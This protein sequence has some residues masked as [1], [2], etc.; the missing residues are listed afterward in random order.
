MGCY[1]IDVDSYGKNYKIN[2]DEDLHDLHTAI[3]VAADLLEYKVRIVINED[4]SLK[5]HMKVHKSR[6]EVYFVNYYSHN[7]NLFGVRTGVITNFGNFREE[8]IMSPYT[9]KDPNALRW[10]LEEISKD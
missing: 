7:N 6:N 5:V 4:S 10:V 2:V 9:S 8:E 1:K 3:L